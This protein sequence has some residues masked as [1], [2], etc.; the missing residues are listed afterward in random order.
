[1]RA[2]GSDPWTFVSQYPQLSGSRF[3]LAG[4][5]ARSVITHNW[6]TYV[7]ASLGD[8]WTTWRTPPVFYVLEGATPDGRLPPD[9]QGTPPGLNSYRHRTQPF[10]PSAVNEPVWVTALLD[11]S[12]LEQL[13]YL[14]L[15]LLLVGVGL[16]LWR[17]PRDVAAFLLLALLGAV[18]GAMAM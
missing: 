4:D 5:Y 7:Q 16:W 13:S 12:T 14:L 1:V 8:L 17:R 15:P 18:L 9:D 11:L 10:G 3:V 6:E 2:G